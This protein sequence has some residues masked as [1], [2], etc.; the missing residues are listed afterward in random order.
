MT[1]MTIEELNE[2]V[3]DLKDRLKD[4]IREIKHLKDVND[5]LRVSLE[6]AEMSDQY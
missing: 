3:K 2:R 5:S 6:M 1:T 4:A